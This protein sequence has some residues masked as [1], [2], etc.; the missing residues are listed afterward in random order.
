MVF[1]IGLLG[2]YLVVVDS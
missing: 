2:W 1:V